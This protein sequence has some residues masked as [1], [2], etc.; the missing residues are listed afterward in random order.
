M[1]SIKYL[2]ATLKRAEMRVYFESVNNSDISGKIAVSFNYIVRSIIQ[3][4]TLDELAEQKA[5]LAPT[6]LFVE[7]IERFVSENNFSAL[8]NQRTKFG[9]SNIN[10][11]V[12]EYG[13]PL[14]SSISFTWGSLD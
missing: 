3:C 14:S 2:E 5:T 8:F 7:V 6:S 10:W 13:S 12:A 1:L 11:R 9:T 4:L